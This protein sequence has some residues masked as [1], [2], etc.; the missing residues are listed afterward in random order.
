MTRFDRSGWNA[1]EFSSKTNWGEEPSAND[2]SSPYRV[3]KKPTAAP[4][5]DRLPTSQRW[6]QSLQRQQQQQASTAL[7]AY[8]VDSASERATGFVPLSP[9]QSFPDID[10]GRWASAVRSG[11]SDNNDWNTDA[12]WFDTGSPDNSENINLGTI[13]RPI[14]AD[15]VLE[16][17]ERDLMAQARSK[18]IEHDEQARDQDLLA[19]RYQRY[20]PFDLSIES[21][22]EAKRVKVGLLRFFGGVSAAYA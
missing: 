14:D 7:E 12:A 15:A 11:S 20:K 3:S 13:G 19:A 1:K 17:R 2:R 4:S 21:D 16:A 5:P 6:S 8:D 22:A 9:S 10:S 18:K